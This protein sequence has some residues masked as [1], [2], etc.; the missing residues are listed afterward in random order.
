MSFFCFA[1]LYSMVIRNLWTGRVMI[2]VESI[3]YN[4]LIN[5]IKSAQ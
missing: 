2:C 5:K 4:K 3:Q 1:N